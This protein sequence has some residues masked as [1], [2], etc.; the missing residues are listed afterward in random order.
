M[1]VDY[2]MAGLKIDANRMAN[3]KTTWMM[4]NDYSD[5]FTGI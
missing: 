1:E 4:H 3:A 5:A 2:F